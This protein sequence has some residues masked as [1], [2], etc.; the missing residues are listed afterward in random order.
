MRSP[1]VYVTL[2]RLLYLLIV[3]ESVF[4]MWQRL[5][6]RW[7]RDTY[8]ITTD[9]ERFELADCQR[10]GRCIA[11]QNIEEDCAR[12]ISCLRIGA[13]CIS[14]SVTERKRKLYL[15]SVH[16]CDFYICVKC[17]FVRVRYTCDLLHII[18]KVKQVITLQ[19]DNLFF[20]IYIY[21]AYILH[22]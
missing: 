8:S 1:I 17:E 9:L 14:K 2:Y 15:I 19:C 6:L 11:K 16:I 3:Q 20:S 12:V 13:T 18:Y 5:S 7:Y 22:I 4:R 21:S 10:R